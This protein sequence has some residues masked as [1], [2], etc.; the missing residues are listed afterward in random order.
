MNPQ[1]IAAAVKMIRGVS[2]AANQDADN[3]DRLASALIDVAAVREAHAAGTDD[4]KVKTANGLAGEFIADE[5]EKALPAAIDAAAA[6]IAADANAIM[7]K[8]GVKA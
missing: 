4:L 6:R 5:L 7:T 2:D 3:L 1:E 8:Y